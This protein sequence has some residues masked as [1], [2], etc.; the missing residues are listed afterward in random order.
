MREK[1]KTITL[2]SL[3]DAARALDMQFIYGFIPN[4]KNLAKMIEDRADKIAQDVVLKTAKTMQ[5]ESQA[6]SKSRIKK[7]IKERKKEIIDN[8]PR[9]LWDM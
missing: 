5:L 6:N 4:K 7:A 8:M 1:N 2:K 3:E 9:Y